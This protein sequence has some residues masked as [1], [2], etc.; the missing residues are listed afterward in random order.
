MR[1]AASPAAQSV[2][3]FEGPFSRLFFNSS[4]VCHANFNHFLKAF[5]IILLNTVINVAVQFQTFKFSNVSKQFVENYAML[6]LLN[7]DI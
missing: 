5:M 7:D 4:C 6:P 2:P 1:R 3:L